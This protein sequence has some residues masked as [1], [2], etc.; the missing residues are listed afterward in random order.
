MK[1]LKIA[2]AAIFLIA[3]SVAAQRSSLKK[4]EYQKYWAKRA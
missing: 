4:A 2:T 1:V 3:T